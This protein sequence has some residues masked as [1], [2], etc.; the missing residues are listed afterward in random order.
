MEFRCF[1][2]QHLFPEKFAV[3]SCT[4]LK[5]LLAKNLPISYAT[6][7]NLESFFTINKYN[8]QQEGAHSLNTVN[9]QRIS[10]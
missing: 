5:H 6:A 8:T 4:A 1:T 3:T 10:E 7:D 2:S 9:L